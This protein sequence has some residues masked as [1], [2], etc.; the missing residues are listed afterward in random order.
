[1]RFEPESILVAFPDYKEPLFRP[2]SEAY[3]AIVQATYGCSH[4]KCTF[5]MM[6]KGKKF[7]ARP[8]DEV[9]HDLDLLAAV[10]PKKQK[11]FLADGDAMVLSTGRLLKILEHARQ[12]FPSLKRT[13][14][15]ANP[16]NLLQKSENELLSLQRAGL[17]MVYLGLESGDDLVLKTI[18]KGA[19]RDEIVEAGKKA[20]RAGMLLS[21]TVLLGLGGR[22]RSVKHATATARALTDMAPHYASA[23]TLMLKDYEKE[24]AERCRPWTR[25]DPMETLMEL[26]T[27]I[28]GI[29]STGMVFRTNHASNYLPLKGILSEDRDRLL[30][31]LNEA[32]SD[33]S[34]K[35]LRPE[36]AR[37]L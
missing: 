20:V 17:K 21:V 3:S 6:Y 27:L 18:Q 8:L 14:V 13:A 15:Y 11:L 10:M 37:G 35:Y 33:R 26:K 31:I 32:M 28:Q 12:V 4:N 30:A 36:W 5:C 2:P 7:R 24:F 19:T 9:L 23:L 22:E 34:G 16:S 25:L 29:N 1:M